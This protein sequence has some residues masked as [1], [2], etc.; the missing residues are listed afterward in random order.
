MFLDTIIIAIVIGFIRGGKLR[1]LGEIELRGIT[2]FF[3]GFLLQILPTLLVLKGFHA[4]RAFESWAHILSYF[5]IFAG[6]YTDRSLPGIAILGAGSFLNFLVIVANGGKMPVSID[7][8]QAIG[9]WE[10]IR[11]LE[12]GQMPMY[13][14]CKGDL[15]S[16]LL[17][18]VLSVPPFFRSQIFSIGDILMA[19]GLFIFIQSAMLSKKR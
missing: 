12:M 7:T 16:R 19:L 15:L 5:F 10:D 11:S 17:G 2:F 1:K 8:L 13:M 3:I 6:I 4:L 9:K 14:A 18:D